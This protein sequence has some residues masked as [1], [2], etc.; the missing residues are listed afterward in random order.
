MESTTLEDLSESSKKTD[1]ILKSKWVTK[2]FKGYV[3][4]TNRLPLSKIFEVI[5]LTS[6]NVGLR[7]LALI[8]DDYRLTLSK[9]E[10]IDAYRLYPEISKEQKKKIIFVYIFA[11]FM[12]II[13]ITISVMPELLFLI[14]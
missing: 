5:T 12:S 4:M 1:I 13:A 11:A 6:D 14:I 8:R 7:P 10:L 3:S 2:D 9:D